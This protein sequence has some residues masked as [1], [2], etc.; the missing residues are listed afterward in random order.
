MKTGATAPVEEV[1]KYTDMYSPTLR[2]TE[3]DVRAKFSELGK[4]FAT[5]KNLVLEGNT[6][7]LPDIPDFSG[8]TV[9][10]GSPSVLNSEETDT[11]QKVI[12]LDDGTVVLTD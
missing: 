8:A 1:Q 6:D 5:M 9:S 7:E 3:A 4:F 11:G 12:I 10:T 2:D